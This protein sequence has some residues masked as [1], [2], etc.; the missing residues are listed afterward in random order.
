MYQNHNHVFHTL[1]VT[2]LIF[3]VK[4][5]DKISDVYIASKSHSVCQATK[6]ICDATSFTDALSGT[7]RRNGFTTV[8][9]GPKKPSN[10]QRSHSWSPLACCRTRNPKRKHQD[11]HYRDNCDNRNNK[12]KQHQVSNRAPVTSS[13]NGKRGQRISSG[14]PRKPYGLHSSMM[15]CKQNLLTS[16]LYPPLWTHLTRSPPLQLQINLFKAWLTIKVFSTYPA[17]SLLILNTQHLAEVKT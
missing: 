10:R 6:K 4:K 14:E 12:R 16:K 8:S 1:L 17:M 13:N 15:S 9:N 11:T 7:C 2:R 3:F 5:N